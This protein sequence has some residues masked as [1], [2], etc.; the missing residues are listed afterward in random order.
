MGKGGDITARYRE[1]LLRY[2]KVPS[3]QQLYKGELLS[4]EAI[5]NDISPEEIIGWHQRILLESYPDLRPEVQRSL[6]FLLEVMSGYGIVYRE[7]RRLRHM[8]EELKTE[9]KFAADMQN[10][11]LKTRIPDLPELG[12]GVISVPAKYM[13]GD[14]CHFVQGEDNWVGFG[15]A[16]VVG[17][18]IPAALCMSMVKYAMDSMQEEC[19]SPGEVL[20]VLNRVVEQNVDDSMFITM[21]YSMYNLKTNKF[22]YASA[23]HEP[24][25]F[26]VAKENRFEELEARGLLL[27]I[28]PDTEYRQFER[29]VEIGDMIILMSDGVTECRTEN[30]FIE[31]DY[32]LDVIRKYLHLHPREI[33]LNVYKHFERLQHFQLRDDFTLL[34]LKRAE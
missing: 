7:T 20:K 28:N 2:M 3:E 14:Y 23:G 4:K 32:L 33:V 8:Q 9:M 24:G 31:R 26:Y 29:T 1:E 34:I 13:N 11:L 6:D 5:K 21:L 12:I 16:D 22:L 10:S 18:G 27:G 30:G 19:C 17:K 25:I 15:I